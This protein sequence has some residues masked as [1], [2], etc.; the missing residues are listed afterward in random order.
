MAGRVMA[1]EMSGEILHCNAEYGPGSRLRTWECVAERWVARQELAMRKTIERVL[2]N[3]YPSPAWL[4]QAFDSTFEWVRMVEF[5]QDDYRSAAFLDRRGLR[6]DMDAAAVPFSSL[7]EHTPA[8]ARRDAH[9]IF[10]IGHVG[11]TLVSRLLGELPGV[12][13]LREP[14]VLRALPAMDAAAQNERLPVVRALLSRTFAAEQ[15]ALIKATSYLSELA[16]ALV[17]PTSDGGKTL[18]IGMCAQRFIAARL[19]TPMIE[20]RARIPERMAR[21]TRRAPAIDAAEASR[22]DAHVAAAAWATEAS[23]L[24]AAA[25]AIGPE[26]AQFLDFDQFLNAPVEGLEEVA[27][28]FAFATD[29]ED[30][31]RLIDGPVMTHHAKTGDNRF[32][33]TTREARIA[34]RLTDHATEIG[35]AMRWLERLAKDAPSVAQALDRAAV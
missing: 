28:H 26:R 22:D 1:K 30:L 23:A 2:A 17:G 27:S 32:D 20:P 25:A 11:S 15:R 14:V 5:E 35:A 13:A 33:P 7:A 31:R 29:R 9:W 34:V 10:H 6:P 4:P 8:E 21:L 24:E 3:L 18:M 12:F 16:P 19:D